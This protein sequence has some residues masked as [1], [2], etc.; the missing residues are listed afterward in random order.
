MT[1]RRGVAKFEPLVGVIN[2][3]LSISRSHSAASLANR[4]AA[5]SFFLFSDR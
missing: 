1:M 3:P 4:L 5:S 2:R